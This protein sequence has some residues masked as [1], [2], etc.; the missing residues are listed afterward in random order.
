MG[1]VKDADIAFNRAAMEVMKNHP[2]ILIND[3]NAFVRGSAAFDKWREGSDVHFWGKTE[4]SLVGNAVAEAVKNAL[5]G[6]KR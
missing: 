1:R 2:E 3:L 5:G 6:D 4:S